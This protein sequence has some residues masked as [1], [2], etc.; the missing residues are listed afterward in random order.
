MR[1]WSKINYRYIIRPKA[2]YCCISY[3]MINK[4]LS[5]D[6]QQAILQI[7]MIGKSKCSIYKIFLQH[8][9]D[10]FLTFQHISPKGALLLW[11]FS[12]FRS[13]Y[14]SWG[15]RVSAED[16]DLRHNYNCRYDGVTE[17]YTALFQHY[18]I[19]LRIFSLL[20]PNWISFGSKRNENLSEV[21]R[22]HKIYKK[23]YF[24]F[25]KV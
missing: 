20:K 3:K 12:C 14:T 13:D 7:G 16:F 25:L 15:D 23:E 24:L 11:F 8:K 21:M 6:S 2:C 10:S 5:T 9:V 22:L 18:L 4:F 17:L 19:V 1:F